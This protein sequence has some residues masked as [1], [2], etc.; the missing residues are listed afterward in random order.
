MAKKGLFKKFHRL[1]VILLVIII[2]AAGLAF[3]YFVLEGGSLNMNLSE[4]KTVELTLLIPGVRKPTVDNIEVGDIVKSG[5]TNK[6]LG[7][8]VDK[9]V[10]NA[11]MTTT[12]S[13]G[14]VKEVELINKYDCTIVV[15]GSAD[16]TSHDIMMANKDV[17]IGQLLEITTQRIE[18]TP[19]IFG[20]EIIE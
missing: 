15:R 7:E 17:K 20:I 18:T 12:D 4:P 14:Q 6:I 8:I 5:E 3:N 2:A 9:K 13:S 19:V 16:I 10:E 1:D 11:K